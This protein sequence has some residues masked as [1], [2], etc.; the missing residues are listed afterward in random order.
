MHIQRHYMSCRYMKREKP[1]ATF[2][3]LAASQVVHPS[4]S[5][6]AITLT[7]VGRGRKQGIAESVGSQSFHSAARGA[8][9]KRLQGLQLFWLLASSVPSPSGSAAVCMAIASAV[10]WKFFLRVEPTIL[11]RLY[12]LLLPK[13]QYRYAEVSMQFSIL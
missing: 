2:H 10:M 7:V 13:W 1:S 6:T 9:G 5:P 3:L 11:P 4:T 12:T 8:K